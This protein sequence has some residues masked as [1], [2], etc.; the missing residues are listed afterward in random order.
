MSTEH[1]ARADAA[2]VASELERVDEALA[3]V[4]PVI[5]GAGIGLVAFVGALLEHLFVE[6]PARASQHE[7]LTGYRRALELRLTP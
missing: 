2:R 4:Q 5:I 1:L 6:A 3:A 7:R